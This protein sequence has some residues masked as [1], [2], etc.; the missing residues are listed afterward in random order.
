MKFMIGVDFE[1]VFVLWKPNKLL[2][3]CPEYEYARMQATKEAN[4]AASALFDLG[5]EQVIIWDNHSSGTNLI[6]DILDERCNILNGSGAKHRWAG[7]DE[8]FA[9]VLLIGYHPKDNMQEAVLAHTYNSSQYQWMKV[10]GVEVGEIA[11]HQGNYG[12]DE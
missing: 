9:G 5:A 7:L 11:D 8:D 12:I 2:S 10:N 4:A 6:Y 3:D 1:G